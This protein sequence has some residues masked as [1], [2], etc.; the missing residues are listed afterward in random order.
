MRPFPV[1]L[2]TLLLLASPGLLPSAHA[3]DPWWNPAWSYRQDLSLPLDL[4]SPGAPGQPIDLRLT[5]QHPCWT[6]DETHTSLRVIATSDGDTTELES[7]ISN[8]TFTTPE[9]LASCTLVFLLPTTLTGDE[10]LA[11]YYDDA[12]TPPTQYPDHVTITTSSYYLEPLPGY[13]IR[14]SFY[15]INDD[16]TPTYAVSYDGQFLSYT[17]AQFVTR[18]RPNA[19]SVLPTTTDL[20]ASF[21]FKYYYGEGDDQF[22]TTADHATSHEILHD[23]TLSTTIRIASSSHDDSLQTTAVYTYYHTTTPETRIRAH[24]DHKALKDCQVCPGAST[25]GTY[26]QLQCGSIHCTTLPELT[27]D[28][29]YPYLHLHT[30]AGSEEYR[31]DPT[32][33]YSGDDI[34]RLFAPTDNIDL[35]TPP[36]ACFDT[37]TTG[38]AHALL[39]ATTHVL[40]SG[41]DEHDGIQ[42]NAYESNTPNLPGFH[43]TLA[44]LQCNRNSA[45][46]TGTQDLQIPAGFHAAYDAEF[47]T[48]TSGYPQVETEAACYPQLAT[49]L[50]TK[51]DNTTT[52]KPQPL[53]TLTIQVRHAPS[54]PFGEA[55]SILR[56]KNYSYITTEV[57]HGTTLVCSGAAVHIPLR[58]TTGNATLRQTLDLPNA[59]RL[60][61]STFPRLPPG[62]Y[63]IK[64]YR[65]HPL[66]STRSQAIGYTWVT[67]TANTTVQ[68]H[69]TRPAAVLYHVLDQHGNGIPQA[70]VRL[71]ADTHQ[72]SWGTTDSDGTVRLT[73]PIQ[74]TGYNATILY[75][76][77]LLSQQTLRLP[78]LGKASV[79]RTVTTNL[80]SLTLTIRDTWGMPPDIT[81][82][83]QASSPRMYTAQNLSLQATVPGRYEIH[84]LPA[85][86]YTLRVRYQSFTA[87]TSISLPSS[88]TAEILFPAEY[89]IRFRFLDARGLPLPGL[90]LRLSRGNKTVEQDSTGDLLG[91]SLPPGTYRLEVQS[92]SEVLASR[93]LQVIGPR[94]VTVVT[95]QDPTGLGFLLGCIGVFGV[96][97]ILGYWRKQ[98]AFL[99][100]GAC[101]VLIIGSLWFPWWV[102]AGSSGET[103]VLSQLFVVPGSL[104]SMVQT[105]QVLS[106]ELAS[107]PDQF[108]FV[109]TVFLGGCVV[110][111]GLLLASLAFL[112]RR[113]WR[114]MWVLWLG[115]LLVLVGSLV[116]VLISISLVST[117][118]MGGMLGSGDFQ[119]VVPGE[120]LRTVPAAWGPGFGCVLFI[121]ALVVAGLGMFIV[122][123]K[124]RKK[125]Q[126]LL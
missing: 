101:I 25:D 28:R 38:T 24:I 85:A 31:I 62:D 89:H 73:V 68:V 8:L 59:S 106:G 94:E 108:S 75:K 113:H 107:L 93:P 70:E 76:G 19:T 13:A 92:T 39:F 23:G 17:T 86:P 63:L 124:E 82:I 35:A 88:S 120:D 1:V 43:N 118:S 16:T 91:I 96:G 6:Q 55:L 18:L 3:Q 116:L 122:L 4:H 22:A 83:P 11:V 104:V 15:I 121:G 125:T 57:Y 126:G 49:L 47:F 69:C 46:T 30:T 12:P 105:P 66:R 80:S 36:W 81:L 87:N 9:Q 34:T 72:V 14:S 100:A 58:Q 112:R 102:I 51:T 114:V 84:G 32:P 45:D 5:L 78:R 74:Q 2:L 79:T 48:T 103:R 20:L 27:I 53:Y 71:T 44:V 115:S 56:G 90:S 21:E 99:V 52:Q 41:T 54:M 117:V 60:K 65:N 109:M 111:C 37:G 40:T 10:T 50:S 29:L 64:V 77:F 7:E 26:A 61:T 67:L 97:A 33:D 119:A 95:G 110:G 98:W 123:R 42:A